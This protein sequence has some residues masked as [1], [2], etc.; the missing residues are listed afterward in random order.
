M[1]LCD[2]VFIFFADH[3]PSILLGLAI[4]IPTIG[5]NIMRKPFMILFIASLALMSSVARSAWYEVTGSSPVL[6]SKLKARERALEDAVYQALLF[7]G[8][9]I[10]VLP[11]IR[12]YLKE[13][14]TDYQFSGNEI[15]HIQVL[16]TKEIGGVMTLTTRIDIY[17]TANSCHSNQYRKSLLIGRFNIASLQDAA[18]GGIFQFGDD[19]TLLLQRRF[20]TQAQSFVAQGIT[21]Y[22]ISSSQSDRT[23][24]IAQDSGAQYILI[25]EIND[26]SA[27]SDSKFL[28]KKQTNRQLAMNID[29]LDGKSGEVIYQNSYRDIA[30]WPFDRQSKVETK[31]ARFWTSPYG[32]MAQ[33]MSKNILLDLESHLSCRATTSE[34]VSINDEQGQINVGRIHGVKHGD[35][36]SL[37]HNASFI[38][39]FGIYRTQLKKSKMTLTV[40]RVYENASEVTIYPPEYAPSIQIGDIATKHI[41]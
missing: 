40:N 39:Q 41:Q 6:E 12:P 1:H 19:F 22:K 38:D 18:L 9:D 28:Q 5:K 20:E 29:V 32:K 24:L 3:F 10:G 13:S 11:R 37:W 17:P 33:Q 26:M 15:R 27:T 8:G 21:P 36:L 4:F 14:R 31:S 34:I 16:K 25:G 35:K 2:H 30:K 7:S 23:R